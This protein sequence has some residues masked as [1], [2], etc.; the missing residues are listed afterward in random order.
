MPSLSLGTGLV[1]PLDLTAA[2]ATFPNGGLSS[3]RAAIVRVLDADGGVA[4]DNPMQSERVLSVQTAYQMV[5]MLGDVV[6]RGTGQAVRR[7]GL[8]FPVA[9][10]TGTT[11]DFK[12]AWF[13]GFSS[14]LVVG[15]WV[16]FDQ[17]KTIGRDA[18]GSRYAAPIWTEFMRRAARTRAAR[19]LR[20]A[21]RSQGS[22]ALP[23]LVSAAGRRVS[24]LHRVPQARRQGAERPVHDPPRQHQA[25]GPARARGLVVRRGEADPRHFPVG[26]AGRM[27]RPILAFFSLTYA[28]T[29]TCWAAAAA[30]SRGRTLGRCCPS[31]ARRRPVPSRHRRS[32]TGCAGIDGAGRRTRSDPGAARSRVLVGCRRQVVC[33]RRR[34]HAGGQ[35]VGCAR[36]PVRHWGMAPFWRRSLVPDGDRDRVL[37]LG[38]GGGGNRLAGL[39]ASAT[40]SP[41]RPRARERH[42]RR[43]VG[44]LAPAA[45]FRSGRRYAGTIIPVVPDSGDGVVGGRR[46]GCTGAPAAA[47]S[48]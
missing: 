23:H 46:H 11:D 10:K 13:V 44:R 31:L 34:L 29:W 42:P 14:S 43:L 16:G 8:G 5:S 19:G 30:V 39:R 27:T 6:D 28:A 41:R 4:L 3:R 47:C 21:G 25:A 37:D 24:D 1:T 32:F 17:P 33:V 26:T 36:V 45:V 38:A 12:D 18:Y 15:V 7:A 9:G 35:A 2:Y 22:D 48:S 20:G 40:V